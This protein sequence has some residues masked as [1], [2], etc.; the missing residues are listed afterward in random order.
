MWPNC[1]GDVRKTGIRCGVAAGSGGEIPDIGGG[2]LSTLYVLIIW[3]LSI[4]P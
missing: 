4:L 1:L 3:Y 2:V